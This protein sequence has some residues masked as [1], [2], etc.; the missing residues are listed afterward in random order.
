MNSP[1]IDGSLA[2]NWM[3]TYQPPSGYFDEFLDD[4]GRPRPHWKR[5]ADHF[6]KYNM[7][8]WRA[9]ERQL[10]RLIH[11]NGITYNVYG[12][13]ESKLRPWDLDMLPLAMSQDEHEKLESALSQR[14][15]LLNLILQDVY[16]R[17]TVLRDSKFNPFLVFANPS[18]LRPC[19]GLLPPRH[20]YL[21]LYAADIARAPDGNWWV[22][23]DRAEA[24]SGLG[25]ALENR[26]LMS[27]VFPKALWEAEVQ[28]LDPF[29]QR[30]C[31][32][33]ESIAQQNTDSPN[34]ALLTAGPGNE[35]YFEQSFLARNLGYTLAE[36]ADL[37]VRNNRLYMKTI[38]G[39]QPVDVLLRRV[40][41]E[42]CDPLELRNESLIGIPGLVNAVRQGN[43]SVAN[44]LGSGFVEMTAMH[45]FLPWLSRSFLGET[46]EI[47]SVATWW[48]GQSKECEY[49]IENIDKLAIKPTFWGESSHTY[50]GPEL[51]AQE[52]ENLI[53][54]IRQN[55]ENYCGQEIVSNGTIP[56]YDDGK[57]KSRHFQLR[58]FLVP[59]GNGWKMMPGGL[60]RHSS[61]ENNL[62]VSMQR[63]GESKDAWVSRNREE[64]RGKRGGQEGAAHAPI[65]RQSNDLPSRT[66]NNLFWLGRYLERTESQARLLRTLNDLLF[67][68]LSSESKTDIIP[69]LEQIVEPETDISEIVDV[70]TGETDIAAAEQIA[71]KA[72]YDT[73][74]YESLVSNL[75]HIEQ[76][77]GKVKD[78]LSVDT[79]KR[80][81]KLRDLA[82]AKVRAN[83][84]VFDDE[85]AI[86][87]DA[88][89]DDL[90]S[91]VGNLTE[92]MTRSQ[93]WRFLQIGRR[94]ER[95][96]SI[97]YL[98]RSAFRS[99][100]PTSETLLSSML[101]WADSS[102]TYRR[103]YLNTLQAS[104]V[105][106]L[107]CFDTSNPR[108]LAFQAESL[109]ELVAA[110]PH[111][112]K[113]D[114]HP[115]DMLSLRLYSRLGLSD[116][117]ALLE[118]GKS[119]KRKELEDFFDALCDD[120]LNLAS[121]IEKT[122][123]AHTFLLEES[124]AQTLIG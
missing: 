112:L 46:L 111:R 51:S 43:L 30:F 90:A 62:I 44:S 12:E 115:I 29:I 45:A 103:R 74:N 23:S 24:A 3:G 104:R 14:A 8:S 61:S 17:Q 58:V 50:F 79:W 78:R 105:L 96:I 92:N 120:F 25:Y 22:L 21:H 36:G 31:R 113:T 68:Q 102:I 109:R 76:A 84:S 4:K 93:G 97:S 42:W 48:C 15:H 27:R 52:K 81:S 117:A 77:A 20:R 86:L 91:F 114:R 108:S 121:T 70:Q 89:L 7:D 56:I 37:T 10:Q 124:K 5:I 57:L 13:D 88:T 87:L 55:P 54:M 9:R 110:L 118:R 119:R 83:P 122:Y 107:L 99:T 32:H 19:H 73:G 82:E 2:N 101:I 11:D 116:P 28:S 106:D 1:P 59:D 35:T 16:G 65:R 75:K 47:P 98:L 33:I 34:I 66:A 38:G 6:G 80:A 85:T 123:F 40:D 71:I 39:V 18:F 64:A 72:I 94:A 60:V 69:F 41:S 53:G 63:G 49:V 100:E 26:M 95:G 67:N